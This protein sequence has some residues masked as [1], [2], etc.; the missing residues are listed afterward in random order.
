MNSRKPLCRWQIRCSPEAPEVND[1]KTYDNGVRSSRRSC[2]TRSA[3]KTNYQKVLVDSGY[4][5]QA[6]L[7]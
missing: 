5:T 2:S 4:Y 7:A 1:T 6:Q 3:D